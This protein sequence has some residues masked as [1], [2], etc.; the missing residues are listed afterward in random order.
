MSKF[1]LGVVFCAVVIFG[2][3][4]LMFFNGQTSPSLTPTSTSVA[5]V[6]L[7][8]LVG[9]AEYICKDAQTILASF[10]DQATTAV[11]VA[12][13]P[14]ITTGSVKLIFTN[15]QPLTLSQTISA[16]GGKYTN[17]DES[18]VFWSKGNGA[19][20]LENNVE[21]NY[22]KCVVVAPAVVG[23]TLPKLFA[24]SE[25]TFSLRLP[26]IVSSTT[27]GYTITQHASNQLSSTLTIDGTRFTIPKSMATGT[28]LSNDSYMSVENIP[29]TASCRAELFLSKVTATSTIT[30]TT[31]T[32]SFASSSGAGAGN[33][34][35]E[36]V[37]ALQGTNPCI[38][39]HYFIHYGVLENYPIGTVKAFDKKAL[40]TQFDQI[41]R[42]LVVNQ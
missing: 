23:V 11:A 3:I 17:T 15:G 7:P 38:A 25:G 14:P 19:L 28:N 35:E 34:Y 20:V 27:D 22:T 24:N 31:V 9:S 26:S 41:R 18:F 33:R 30:D 5:I 2:A 16:D 1:I 21:K 37:Y 32:Y 13:Q 6:P 29:N 40:I 39:V 12:G 4:Y 42:T 10:Y 8:T 36:T